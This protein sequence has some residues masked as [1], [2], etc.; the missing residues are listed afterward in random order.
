M[1]LSEFKQGSVMCSEGE[2]LGHIY[3]ITKGRV[4]ASF[5]GHT[6]HFEAGD[7]I[8]LCA[9]NT[10][11]HSCTYTAASDVTIVSY[12]YEN[13]SSLR[14][15]LY[16]KAD[17]ASRL[18]SSLCRQISVFLGYRAALK[19]EAD[20]ARELI[21]SAYP[22]YERL[23]AL[24]AFSSKKLN[25]IFEITE[26]MS[27]DPIKS[28]VYDYYTEIN[29]LN[30][31]VLKDFFYGNTGITS[32]FFNRGTED[33]FQILESIKLY[34]E[35][36]RNVSK[37]FLNND[38]HD[39]F[40]LVGELHLSSISIKGANE[41]V[42]GIMTQIIDLLSDMTYVDKTYFKERLSLYSES[43]PSGYESG[44]KTA[45]P[46]NASGLKQNLSDSLNVILEYSECPEELCNKFARLVHEYTKL[47]DRSSPDDV[48]YS[49]RKELTVIFNSIYMHVFIKSLKDTA[50]P[51]VIKMFL[52]FGY[53]DATLA[54]PKNADF[55]YSIADSLKGNPAQDVYTLPEWLRAIYKGQKE[56]SRND[57]DMDYPGHL[58]EMKQMRKIDDKEEARLLND[59]EAKLRF[60][61]ENVFPV[62]NKITF[63]RITSFCPVFSDHNVQ[64]DLESALITPSSL[65]KSFDEIR[66]ID[67]TAYY[68]ETLYTNL[69]CGISKEFVHIEVM[70]EIILMPNVGV[71]GA[72]WQEMEGRK[73]ASPARI[74]MPLFFLNDLKS[75]ITRLT[76]EYR[77]EIC[78]RIQGP[79]WSDF[80]YP[81]LTS[82]FFDYMQFYRSNRELSADVKSTIKTELIRARNNYK[83][84]F[85]SN[86]GEWL[87]YES[88][89][90]PRLNKIARRVLL[91]YCPFPVETREKL[92][93]NP[94]F[95]EL[96]KRYNFKLQTRVR[97][98]QNVIQKVEKAG[99][100]VPQ[101]I[102]DELKYIE[103]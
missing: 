2:P 51:T 86:Y 23:C 71:R 1:P 39:L 60:E 24:Y 15:L 27:S 28:W 77:W 88:K 83:E 92:M 66:S 4:N 61:L 74:F 36:L 93:T 89:G 50:L 12:P 21:K 49:L 85:V 33:I 101:E 26:P 76:G 96:F 80:S 47:P 53:V 54:G 41:A 40:A 10:G 48:V 8:G 18:V 103:G 6:F 56:P 78:K 82:E 14:P 98:L 3:F 99:K 64:R 30:P 73:H 72:M 7:T 43:L 32:G 37:I 22:E 16:D 45:A 34:Q 46:P 65:K 59:L 55:L 102:L 19:N 29:K 17:V 31:T 69:D 70:P 58:R 100:K 95:A 5:S 94:Q 97:Q 42:G 11:N 62:V 13:I 79:R 90:S 84:V 44:E 75:L 57:F 67:F 35:Y 38:G 20:A 52:N 63:G 9:L 25:G 68:R 81:S 91:E 87:T